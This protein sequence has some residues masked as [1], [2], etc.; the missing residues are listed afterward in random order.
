MTKEEIIRELRE[1]IVHNLY[2]EDMEPEDIGREMPLFEED[3]LGLDSLDAVEFACF[4]EKQYG[5]EIRDGCDAKR[6][7]FS[8]SN[9]ADYV[10]QE[11]ADGKS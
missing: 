1:F 8:L 7:F 4:L 10:L 9:I 3:G 2:R 11:K 5:I 6:I